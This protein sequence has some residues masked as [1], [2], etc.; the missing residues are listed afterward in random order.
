M[1]QFLS[2]LAHLLPLCRVLVDLLL[3]LS[4][5]CAHAFVDELQ[6]APVVLEVLQ[7]VQQHRVGAA[8]AGQNDTVHA[9]GFCLAR[10]ATGSFLKRFNKKKNYKRRG[11]FS[12][13]P[14]SL[15]R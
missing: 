1:C 13:T 9:C 4:E 7:T 8:L 15:S 5:G 12:E 6:A 14:Q 3:E 2:L 10:F 11:G